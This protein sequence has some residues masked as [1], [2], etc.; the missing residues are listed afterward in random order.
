M[1]MKASHLEA[2]YHLRKTWIQFLSKLNSRAKCSYLQSL[3][4]WICSIS[5]ASTIELSLRVKEILP[6]GFPA[7]LRFYFLARLL[8]CLSSFLAFLLS[9]FLASLWERN[10]TH[11]TNVP[12]VKQVARFSRRRAN[13]QL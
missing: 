1:S 7:F 3:S 6:T 8:S 9:C 2:L 13:Q 5:A 4:E 10:S 12:T 11:R